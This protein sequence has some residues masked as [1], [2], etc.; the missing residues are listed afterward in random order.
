MKSD[1]GYNFSP[2][3]L[4]HDIAVWENNKEF[5]L[6]VPETNFERN[7]RKFFFRI[8]ECQQEIKIN[9]GCYR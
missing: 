5:V 2:P 9:Q 1:K 6:Y 7:H 8:M 4:L 3:Y